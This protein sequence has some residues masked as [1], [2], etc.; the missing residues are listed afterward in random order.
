M[1]QEGLTL[2]FL[3]IKAGAARVE[4]QVADKQTLLSNPCVCSRA[5]CSLVGFK[6]SR[7]IAPFPVQLTHSNFLPYKG[8]LTLGVPWPGIS[9]CP[10]STALLCRCSKIGRKETIK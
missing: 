1:A 6:W 9:I 4:V 5:C 3:A 8:L 10:I 2:K 7:N